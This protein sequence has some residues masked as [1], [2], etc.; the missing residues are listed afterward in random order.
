MRV[1]LHEPGVGLDEPYGVPYEPPAGVVSQQQQAR[2]RRQQLGPQD[3]AGRCQRWRRWRRRHPQPQRKCQF[4][5]LELGSA[6][7][8]TG[9]WKCRLQ[10]LMVHDIIAAI[11][12]VSPVR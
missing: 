10:R 1:Q 2:R 3:D 8:S 9:G 5:L 12:F 11:S 7:M 4:Y 6:V